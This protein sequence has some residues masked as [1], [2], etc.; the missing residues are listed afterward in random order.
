[1]VIPKG[2]VIYIPAYWWY[3]FKINDTA[4]MVSFKYQT[5]MSM[6]SILPKLTMY[7]LQSKNIQ[8][9]LAPYKNNI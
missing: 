1:M 2:Q 5:G 6:I 8:R 4:T 3:S 7:F 9:K